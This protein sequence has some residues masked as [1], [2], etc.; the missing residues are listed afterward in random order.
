MLLSLKGCKL[1][2]G[3]IPQKDV[4]IKPGMATQGYAQNAKKSF[5]VTSLTLASTIR[6]VTIAY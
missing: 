3:F 4:S 2:W 1:E 6:N 5:N